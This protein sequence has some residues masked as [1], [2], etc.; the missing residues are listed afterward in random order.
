MGIWDTTLT[1]VEFQQKNNAT[2]IL[3]MFLKVNK[4]SSAMQF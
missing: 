4:N 3:L 1:C 2:N